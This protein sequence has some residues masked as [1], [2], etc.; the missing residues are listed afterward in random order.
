MAESA[1]SFL[2]DRLLVLSQE[3]V[4]LLRGVRR[5]VEYIR[6]ELQSIRGFLRDADAREES[7]ELVKVWVM[8]VRDVAYEIEDVLDDFT[9]RLATP[10]QRRGFVGSL[11]KTAHFVKHLKLRR[12]IANKIQDIKARVDDISERRKRYDLQCHREQGSN[13]NSTWLDLRGNALLIEEAELVGIDKPREKLIGWLVKGELR[14]EVVS[15]YGMGGL[16]KTTLVKKVYDHDKVREYFKHHAWVTVSQSTVSQSFKIKELLKDM[17][18][19]LF[20]EIE[21]PVPQGLDTMKDEELKKTVKE[22]LVQK[23]YVVIFDDMWSIQAWE[24][25]KYALPDSNLGSR[26]MI[27]TRSADI[28]FSC[29]E[30]YGHVYNLEPL[31]A[32]ESWNLFCKKTFGGNDCPPQLEELSHRMLRRC[33]GLPLAIVAIGGVLST[34][35][36]TTIEW[37]MVHRSLGSDF[38]NNDKLNRVMKILSLS[39]HDLP[40][41]LK[42]CFLYLSFFPEDYLIKCKRLMKLWMAEGFVKERQKMTLEEVAESY[43]HELINRSL[44]QIAERGDEGRVQRCRVH[45]FMHDMILSNSRNENFGAIADEHN[46]KLHEGVRRLSIYN[47]VENVPQSQNFS[48]LRSLSMFGVHTLSNSSMHTFFSGFRLLKVLDLK[49]APLEMLPNEFV[50]LFHLRYLSLRRT[51]IKRLPNSIGKLQNLVTLDLKFTPVSELPSEILK[52]Q[53]LQYLAVYNC[54]SQ[55]VKSSFYLNFEG[56]KVQVGIGGLVNLQKLCHVEVNQGNNIIK[57]LGRLTQ[58]R[59]LGIL[60][61]RREDGMDLCSSIEKMSNLRSLSVASTNNEEEVLDLQFPSSP[62]MRLQRLY[63]WGRLEKLPCWIPS[64]DNLAKI[65]L[66]SSR[67][68]DDPL[69]SLQDLPN[70]A[71]IRLS[72]AYDGEALYF[73]SGGFKS[74]KFL[75]L[76]RLDRLR[77]VRVEDG[78][79]PHLQTLEIW[80]CD[81]LEK[82]PLGIERLTNLKILRFIVMSCEFRETLLPDNEGGDY[83][84]VAHVPNI[85]IWI[86]CLTKIFSGF[87]LAMQ[88]PEGVRFERCAFGDASKRN[89]ESVP[90]K[91]EALPCWNPGWF[92]VAAGGPDGGSGLATGCC[93]GLLE[94]E[95]CST[96]A[97]G[98][99]V[100]LRECSRKSGEGYGP[101]ALERA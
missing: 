77:L 80:E 62:P 43:L 46:T 100:E 36:R 3:E 47:S 45:D 39:Y 59:R 86:Y 40:Y 31:D 16:G 42:P 29:K 33:E 12:G 81:K 25:V 48:H 26:I 63:M 13:S 92:V 20:G 54:S 11:Y 27:T 71:E 95:G 5:E 83:L 10:H 72:L 41:Y 44:I 1:V 23:R 52:L 4:K 96:D 73:K 85:S 82:V 56:F 15:V 64:L 32:Q 74:L 49:G 99:L 101:L 58:L 84:K 75:L 61:L 79:M 60:K 50:N 9:L 68:I 30:T 88:A 37:E 87:L 90:F 53:R 14:L 22:F 98:G 19:Q 55:L 21:Q 89:R 57:E 24:A 8:Q 70:L 2:L 66:T 76:Q 67:L 94:V 6:D 35:D 65:V 97:V 38:E 78:A 51:R 7:E 69:E 34:K 28:A 93:E 18:K 91:G 17:I